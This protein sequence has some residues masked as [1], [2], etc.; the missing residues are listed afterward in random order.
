MKSSQPISGS[1]YSPN[2]VEGVF[3]EVPLYGVLGSWLRDSASGIMLV[4]EGEIPL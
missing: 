4:V 1:S 3:S 2:L